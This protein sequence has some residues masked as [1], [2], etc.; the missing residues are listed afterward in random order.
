MMPS[1]PNSPSPTQL[2][3]LL[4]IAARDGRPERALD[5]VAQGANPKARFSNGATALHVAARQGSICALEAL[6]PFGDLGSVDDQGRTPLMEGVRSGRPAVALLL[7]P[8]SN[9][10]AASKDG[11]TALG[12]AISENFQQCFDVLFSSQGGCAPLAHEDLTALMLAADYSRTSMLKELLASS[13]PKARNAEGWTALMFAARAGASD[14][15][16]ILAPRSDLEARCFATDWTAADF[17]SEKGHRDISEMLWAMAASQRELSLFNDT[18]PCAPP[19]RA[20]G[21]L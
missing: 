19:A 10:N 8:L 12:L 20:R 6:L 11:F 3:L 21:R 1:P 16:N 5:L 18:C 13:D 9:A 2:D 15:V 7:A 14:I 17:A 4:F